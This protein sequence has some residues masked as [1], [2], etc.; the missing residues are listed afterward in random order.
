MKKSYDASKIKPIPGAQVAVVQASWH[1][2]HT[3]RM[4]EASREI[5]EQAQCSAVDVFVVPGSYEIPL[6]AKKLAALGKYDAIFVYGIIV[7]GET[8][9][10][11]VIVQTCIRELGKVMYDFEVPIIMEILPVHDI[12][13]AI[14]R[15][16]GDHN[17]GIEAALAAIDLIVLYRQIEAGR[18]VRT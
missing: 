8:D 3:D 12:E 11:D 5:L 13:H 4:V 7:K 16:Q 1:K 14:A 6:T 10:Y 15:T 9:H 18:A 17:K 2:D